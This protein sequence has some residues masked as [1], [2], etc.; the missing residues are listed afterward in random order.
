M[1][2]TYDQSE[3]RNNLT[4]RRDNANKAQGEARRACEPAAALGTELRIAPRPNGTVLIPGISFVPAHPMAA[5]DFAKFHLKRH[6]VGVSAT[7]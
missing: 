7:F 1:D 2:P 3:V 5:I 6:A 4:S